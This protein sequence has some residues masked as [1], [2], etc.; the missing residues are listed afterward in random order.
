MKRLTKQKQIMINEL[1]NFNTFFDVDEFHNKVSNH[2]RIGIAT[3]YRFLSDLENEAKIHSYTCNGRKIYSKNRNNHIHFI[4]EKCNSKKHISI[5]KID[6]ISNYKNKVC[7][8]QLD[9]YG[10]CDNCGSN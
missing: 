4:C 2:K 1:S 9:M 10:I 3:I 7:H 8:F 5:D 6:F